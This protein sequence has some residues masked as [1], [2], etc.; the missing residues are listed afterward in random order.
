MKTNGATRTIPHFGARTMARALLSEI[1]A[2]QA[3]RTQLREQLARLGALTVIERLGK[4]MNIRIAP[5]YLKVRVSEL[6]WPQTSSK[7]KQKRRRRNASS[8]SAYARSACLSAVQLRCPR[9][10]LF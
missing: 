5:E 7:K 4:T 1:D 3:E 6:E 2:L 10:L 9:S 8:V